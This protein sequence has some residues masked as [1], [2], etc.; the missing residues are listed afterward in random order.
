MKSHKYEIIALITGGLLL[1]V[2]GTIFIGLLVYSI[3]STPSKE[4]NRPSPVIETPG[5]QP[6]TA[7]EWHKVI[8]LSGSSEKRSKVFKLSGAEA[9]MRYKL[10]GN[11]YSFLA[12]Y[13]VN[14]GESL[15]ETGGFTEVSVD[16]DT[17]DSTRIVKPAGEYYLDVISGN[18]NWEV[19][20]EEYK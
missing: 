6:V 15:A 9:R 13:I 1:I 12:I 3:N 5:K 4:E 19:T 2:F 16:G 20:I 7:K 11:N 17:K 18:G 10:D 8:S 14:E